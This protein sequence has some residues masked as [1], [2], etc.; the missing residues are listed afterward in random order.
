MRALRS[1]ALWK[2]SLSAFL[3]TGSLF[4][5]S[6]PATPPVTVTGTASAT[7]PAAGMT[8]PS[9][10]AVQAE[11]LITQ[12]VALRTQQRDAEALALFEQANTISPSPRALAQIALA[13]QALNRWVIAERHL[14]EAL[15]ATT[16]AWISRNTAPLHAALTA[17]EGHLGRLDVV[18]N[19]PGAEIWIAAVQVGTIPLQAPVRVPTGETPVEIRATGYVT[20]THNVT[21]Q[22]GQ[23]LRES[24]TLQTVPAEVQQNPFG[25]AVDPNA[26]SKTRLMLNFG[27]GAG[28]SFFLPTVGIGV[29]YGFFQGRFEMQGRADVALFV[30]PNLANNTAT[31]LT[32]LGPVL[33]VD[34][35]FRVRPISPTSIWY[36]GLGIFG[37]FGGAFAINVPPQMVMPPAMPVPIGLPIVFYGVGIEVETGFVFGSR[38]QWD[39]SGRFQLGLGGIWGFITLG[40]GF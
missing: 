3:C 22:A 34:G 14:R 39:L 24:F 30:Q 29:R 38:N 27:V 21:I 19:V 33:A 32:Y 20:A 25:P 5:Q 18:A 2:L 40:Y 7:A 23:T 12:G 16:D 15:A 31:A 28:T 17:I 4:A 1:I 37:K 35:T 8:A 9:P 36:A 26:T 13:E 10:P 6:A 11:S